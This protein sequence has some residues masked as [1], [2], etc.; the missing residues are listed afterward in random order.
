MSGLVTTAAIVALAAL[1]LA[2]LQKR[3]TR[4]ERTFLWMALAAHVFAA[5]ALVYVT[6]DVY[7]FGDMLGYHRLGRTLADGMSQDFTGVAPRVLRLLFQ[8]DDRNTIVPFGTGTATGSMLAISGFIVFAVGNSLHAACAVIAMGAFFGTLAI[9]SVFRANFPPIYRTR[10]L[11]ATLFVPSVVFWSSGLLKEAAAMCGLGAMVWGGHAIVQLRKRGRGS[12]ALVLG[13]VLVG[14]V[15]AYILIAFFVAAGI[16]YY[17]QAAAVSGRAMHLRLRPIHFVL[18]TVVAVVFTLGLGKLYPRYDITSL[19]EQFATEQHLGEEV[20]GGSSYSVGDPSKRSLGAQLAFAPL[21]L[22]TSLFR[23]AIVE[24]R[25][26]QMAINGLEMLAFTLL[27]LGTIIRL[28]LVGTWRAMLRS[29]PLMFCL[30]F[31]TVLALGVG[32]ST[33]NLGTLSRYRMPLMPF[34]AVMLAVL[35]PMGKRSSRRAS[36]PPAKR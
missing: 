1:L 12:I 4:R 36:R 11:I 35:F 22:A 23:P 26:P 31:V 10:L 9:Y 33:T 32:L 19:G 6:R 20:V 2:A 16:W 28:R 27:V 30:V 24:A 34:Y 14:L 15:K 18:G 13:V 3:Y 8:L 7:G 5:V 21:A 17:W 25:N 29:P